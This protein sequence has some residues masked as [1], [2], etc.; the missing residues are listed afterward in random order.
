MSTRLHQ[1]LLWTPRLLGIAWAIF[2][3]IPALHAIHDS[4][5]RSPAV[6]L[7]LHL[8]PSL[9]VAAAVA[10]AWRY[11]LVG[12]I[13]FLVLAVVHVVHTG[14]RLTLPVYLL[15]TGPLVVTGVLFFVSFLLGRPPRG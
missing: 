9:L 11:P 6:A 3:A 10:V 7:F 2:A 15:T 13:A 12:A 14:G 8:L 1:I 5:P 4:G